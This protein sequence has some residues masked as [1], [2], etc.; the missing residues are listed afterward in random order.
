MIGLTTE[1]GPARGG[2]RRLKASTADSA[3]DHN[4]GVLKGTPLIFLRGA[5]AW[6]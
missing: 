1:A 5:K 4:R 3:K 6:F 2:N